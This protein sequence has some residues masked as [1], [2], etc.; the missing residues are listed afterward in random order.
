M[1]EGTEGLKPRVFFGRRLTRRQLSDIRRT[2]E[3]MRGLSRHEL[4]HTVC[5]HLGWRASSGEDSVYA[6][7]KMLEVLER[8]GVVTL[9]AKDE[10]QVRG[11][12]KAPCRSVAGEPQEVIECTL[13]ELGEVTLA[14]ASAADDVS[15]FNELVDRYH[16]LGY[17]QPVGCCMR[18][19]MVDGQGRKLGCLLFQR[20]SAKLKDRDE[21]IGWSGH[22]RQQRLERVACNSRF[23]ILPWVRVGN[24]ASHAL[25]LAAARLADDW[26]ARW[27]VRP[28][29][30]ETFVD[31]EVHSGTVYKAAGWQRIGQS[32]GSRNGST[33][34]KDLYVKALRKD[35][36]AVLCG[37]R[38]TRRRRHEAVAAA[39]APDGPFVALWRDFVGIIAG[40]AAEHDA[41]WRIR[42]RT[43]GT[44][45]VMLFVFRLAFSHNREGYP[46]VIGELWAQCRTLGID[47]PQEHPVA[48]SAMSAARIKAG[49]EVFR[50]VHR[51]I[52][53]R[54]GD[55]GIPRWCGRRLY[56]VDGMKINLPRE[57]LGRGYA[58]PQPGA[59]YPQG[60]VSCLY[61]LNDRMPIDFDLSAHGNER[62]MA[63]DHLQHLGTGDVAVYDRGYYSFELLEA[64]VRRGID[65]VFRLPGS[66]AGVFQ[67][68]DE[69]GE[70]D[71]IV[72][73]LPGR[74]ARRS[75]QRAHPG[76]TLR[77][78]PVRCLRIATA[79]EDFLLATTLADR[80]RFPRSALGEAYHGRWGIEEL[81]KVS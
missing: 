59:W 20:A 56:A 51:R 47:L 16:S 49:D 21:W 18:Y 14:V 34:P 1:T 22:W 48:A 69:S 65:C 45:L 50:E 7:L 5:E 54:M 74:D 58:V 31:G 37:E 3:L 57:L 6:A 36:R 29:L 40:T 62:R 66:S 35:A 27:K 64:H 73:V 43:V 67:R 26:K 80:E 33:G 68:F 19:F 10:S 38:R 79:G 39:A 75:W 9:P 53:A 72:E 12:R 55:D 41:A 77:P 28:V 2:V 70:T 8:E 32:A 42:R 78:V 60:L 44:L 30:V 25:S 23:L 71:C 76:E 52:I 61:R 11:A 81:Y 13:P 63:A 15:L 17:R 4:A 46:V 24:L